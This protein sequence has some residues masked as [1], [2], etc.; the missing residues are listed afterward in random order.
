MKVS[1]LM[2]LVSPLLLL[3]C[4]L[5]GFSF[6][7]EA[8]W[9][10]HGVDIK[11]L[12]PGQLAAIEETINAIGGMK[13]NDVA[14]PKGV[15]HRLSAFRR[16]FGFDFDGEKLKGWLLGRIKSITPENGWT[17]AVNG[18]QGHFYIGGRFFEKSGF[19]ERAY[20]LIHEARH[21]DGNGY[22]H[23]ACPGNYKYVSAGNPDLDLTEV[24][25]CDGV[26]DGAYAFQAAFLF[27]LYAR[28]M[29][30][31]EQAGLVYNNSVARIIRLDAKK[32]KD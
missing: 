18:N 30:N 32:P 1:R 28:N 21:S 19:L 11:E 26:A 13:A 4:L 15:Y 12:S 6:A 31:Q 7:E 24:S 16:L 10:E 22:R 14:I 27:E 17:I 5:P 9:K 8:Y 29:V 3:A 25:A 2:K 23:I 20:C